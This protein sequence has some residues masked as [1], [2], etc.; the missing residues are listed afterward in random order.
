MEKLK[1]DGN[2]AAGTLQAIFAV[3]M[4][5]TS[6]TCDHCGY[7]AAVG[8]VTLYAQAPGLVFRCPTCE[9]VLMK[10][11]T[12]GER[13]WVDLRGLRTLELPPA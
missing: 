10:I 3:E 8:A 13:Y 1:L 5:S 11:V 2:A 7:V 9:S 4:T 6:G 12:D